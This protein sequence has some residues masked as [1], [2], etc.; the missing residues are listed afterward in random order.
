[1]NGKLRN[2]VTDVAEL[3]DCLH[4]IVVTRSEVEGG[5][6]DNEVERVTSIFKRQEVAVID[7]DV[8]G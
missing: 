5:D 3:G 1:V 2:V 8:S 6:W 4:A 7:L